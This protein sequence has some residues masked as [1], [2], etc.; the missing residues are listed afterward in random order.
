MKITID[1]PDDLVAALAD[2]LAARLG[3][4]SASPDGERL[5]G[6]DDA[7]ISRRTWRR[8]VRSGELPGVKIGRELRARRADVSAWLASR[9]VAAGRSAASDRSDV[10]DDGDEMDELLAAGR[11]RVLPGGAGR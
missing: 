8:I 10:G 9:V 6:P 3:A 4:H 11:L 5:I 2:A 7:G 1:L